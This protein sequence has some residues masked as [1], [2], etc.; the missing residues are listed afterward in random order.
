MVQRLAVALLSSPLDI[1]VAL[2]RI[3]LPRQVLS[4]VHLALSL[5]ALLISAVAALIV[6]ALLTV[7]LIK[8]EAALYKSVASVLSAALKAI[9]VLILI[10]PLVPIAHSTG[11]VSAAL[12]NVALLAHHNKM[13]MI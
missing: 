12:R 13:K 10:E 11:L 2:G 8:K 6:V 4:A 7:V 3:L 9:V 1:K 5:V